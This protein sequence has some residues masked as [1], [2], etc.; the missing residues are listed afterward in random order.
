MVKSLRWRLQIWHAIIL[1]GVL[2]IFGTVVYSLHWQTRL[3]QIDAELDRMAEVL[4]ARLRRLLPPGPPPF[5]G[6]G[7]PSSSS[8]RSGDGRPRPEFP[9]PPRDQTRSPGERPERPDLLDRVDHPLSGNDRPGD[10]THRPEPP[11]SESHRPEPRRESARGDRPGRPPWERGGPDRIPPGLGLPE[12]FQ[13]LFEGEDESR[14]YFVIWGHEGVV[15]EKSES[16]PEVPYPDLH[17]GE[18]GLPVRNVRVRDNWREVIHVSR[19]DVNVLVGRSISN[20]LAAEH[21]YGALLFL[22]GSGVLAAGFLGGGWLSARAI[23]PISSMTTTAQ[24]ISAQNLTQRIDLQDTATELG[25]LAV[26]LNGTFD[27][28]QSAFEQ[29]SRFTADASHELR[30]PLAV[31]LAH[32]ELALSRLRSPEEYRMALEACQRASTRMKTLIEGLLMLARFDSKRAVLETTEFEL[33][34]VVHECVELLQPLA[35]PRQIRIETELESVRMRADRSRVSQVITN[36]LTNAIRYNQDQGSVKISISLDAGQTL[37]R[38][39]D[40]GLGIAGDELPHIF[41]RFYRVDKARTRAE[42][43]S[44]LG[45][46]ICKTIVEAHGGTIH[47]TSEPQQGTVVEVRLPVV[48]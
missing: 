1:T 6:P 10:P 19:F 43:G 5:R 24:S 14:F 4:G 11:R 2:T 15:L 12:E 3:Q 44:G 36:L 30:T 29:Q 18:A 16:A 45:L 21:R 28:L 26:V 27:R 33:A 41:E 8:T 48:A 47:V 23:R 13:H 37:I 35:E 39:S 40:T 17:M 20:D 46:S 25:Q 38:V 9:R 7:R 42:G 22:A 32:T 31:I 34:P